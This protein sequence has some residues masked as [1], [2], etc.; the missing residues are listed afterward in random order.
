MLSDRDGESLRPGRILSAF[1]T[2][3]HGEE[4]TRK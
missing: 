4:K 3:L 1:S 2:E